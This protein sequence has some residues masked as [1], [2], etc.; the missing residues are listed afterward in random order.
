MPLITY[1]VVS[2]VIWITLNIVYIDVLYWYIEYCVICC[3]VVSYWAQV[4]IA[5]A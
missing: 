4:D 1:A 3:I 5:V 2:L